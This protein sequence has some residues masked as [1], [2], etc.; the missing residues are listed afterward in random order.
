MIQTLEAG[1]VWVG[2]FTL[3]GLTLFGLTLFGF[4]GKT[5][6]VCV[7]FFTMV[8]GFWDDWWFWEERWFTVLFVSFL[9]FLALPCQ[10][11]YKYDTLGKYYH[12]VYTYNWK[13]I[14]HSRGSEWYFNEQYAWNLS[15]STMLV[16]STWRLRQLKWYWK[17]IHLFYLKS[18]PSLQSPLLW[19]TISHL[20]FKHVKVIPIRCITHTITEKQRAYS[21]DWM[22]MWVSVYIWLLYL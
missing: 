20:P 6:L 18:H 16:P 8:A 14:D 13:N 4:F 2:I 9:S 17:C 11:F 10:D 19:H 7:T 5:G 3:F 1:L 22:G 21:Y 15:L 12:Y